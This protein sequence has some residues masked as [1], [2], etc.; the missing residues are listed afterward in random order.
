MIDLVLEDALDIVVLVFNSEKVHNHVMGWHEREYFSDCHFQITWGYVGESN[1]LLKYERPRLGDIELLNES[2]HQLAGIVVDYVLY[3]LNELES[4]Y[5][6][7]CFFLWA[8]DDTILPEHV[9]KVPSY[10]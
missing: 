5:H 3:L 7:D 4:L 9:H 8:G 1:V 2:P 6:L 10:F